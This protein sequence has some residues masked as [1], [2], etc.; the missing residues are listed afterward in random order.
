M[1]VR[2]GELDLLCGFDEGVG[3]HDHEDAVRED[4]QNDEEREERMDEHVDGHAPDR[5]ER[6]QQPHGVRRAEPEYVLA[7]AHHDERLPI[8][9]VARR[10]SDE[11]SERV[12]LSPAECIIEQ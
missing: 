12:I 1:R 2:D 8:V 3:R 6:R 4:G 7:L 10:E 9:D 11:K 5:V